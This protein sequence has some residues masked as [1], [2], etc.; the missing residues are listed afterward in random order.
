[1]NIRKET[2]CCIS[3]AKRPGNVGAALFNRAFEAM[4]LDFF[5]K[6]FKVD[7]QDL[8]DAIRGV[9]ALGIRG[10]SVSMPYKMEVQ[11]Y[12]DEIDPMAQKIAAVNTIVN[13]Q[14][15]LTGY[16]TDYSGAKQALAEAC[17]LSSKK[18]LIVGAG[19]VSRAIIMAAVELGAGEIFLANRDEQKGRK[20]ATDFSISFVSLKALPPHD[21]FINAT[22]VGMAPDIDNMVVKESDLL[23]CEAV[24]DVVTN[25]LE[26]KLLKTAQRLKKKVIPGAKMALYGAAAQFELYTGQK[27]PLDIF[28]K[29]LST[30]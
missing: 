6:P 22:S 8:G 7:E 10:C 20:L 5:Y 28:H 4:G 9:K 3:I 15:H 17:T 13:E 18:V 2:Q 16:N 1:M 26:S 14:G 30:I 11:P 21:V 27:A 24:M 19:G 25:P 23:S 29:A 12:L